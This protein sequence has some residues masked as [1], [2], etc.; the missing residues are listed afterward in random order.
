VT[1]GL[2]ECVDKKLYEWEW[3]AQDTADKLNKHGDNIRVY[4]CEECCG[5]HL[6]HDRTGKYTKNV[7]RYVRRFPREWV[8]TSISSPTLEE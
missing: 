7:Q 8:K 6:G 5:Y 2:P 1:N 4:Y 3:D